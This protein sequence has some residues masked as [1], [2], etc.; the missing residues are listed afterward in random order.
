MTTG[1]AV[2]LLGV[3]HHGPGSAR[4]VVRALDALAPDVVAIE[5]PAEAEKV[6]G[7]VAGELLP[8]VALLGYVVDRPARAVFSPFAAFS[9]EW[10]ALRWAAAHGA[11]VRAI[12][13]PLAHSLVWEGDDGLR[14]VDPLGAL[15]AAAGY[16]DAERWWEDVVEQRDGAS[17]DDALAPLAAVAEAMAAVRADAPAPVG[18]EAAREACMRAVLR[19]AARDGATVAVVCGAWHVPALTPPWPAVS[20]DAALLRG[21]PKAKVAVT[22]VPW[23]NRRLAAATGYAAGVTAPGWYAHVFAHPGADGVTRWFADAARLLRAR[24]HP[25][26]PDHLIGATRL[27]TAVAALRERPAPGLADVLDAAHAVLTEGRPGPLALIHD[28]LVVGDALGSVPDDVPMVPLARDVAATQRRLRLK[29]EAGRRTLELDLRTDSGRDRSHLLHRLGALGVPWGV[30]EDGRGSSGTFRETW[31]L[32]WE[33]EL[34]I[35]LVEAAALG[36]TVVAAASAALRERAGSTDVLADLTALVEEA[37]LADLPDVVGPLVERLAA[38]A[39]GDADVAHLMDALG[40]LARARRY[41][42]VRATDTAA[43]AGVID[44]M[45]ARITVGVGPACGALDDD[46]AAAMAERLASV[47]AALALVDHPARRSSWPAE[48]ARLAAR[49]GG[50]GV[51]AGRATRL[52]YDGGDWDATAVERRLARAL[53]VGTPPRVGAAFVEGFLAGSG[54]VLVHDTTL[55]AVVDAWLATLAADVFVDVVPLLRRTFGAFAAA[56]RR[57]IGQLLAGRQSTDAATALGWDL[58]PARVEAAL[59]T[60]R[61]LLG[62]DEARWSG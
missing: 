32:H 58:D 10:V 2:H 34:A 15:A 23:T 61:V 42:D 38:R 8:P 46:A 56:E 12:D 49:D 55:L 39:A 35:R 36:T 48:M 6:L 33:P 45:V 52:V 18:E 47:Q 59:G 14:G 27:A 29:P 19:G 7:F 62:D 30:V 37:L 60:M 22:W 17:D 54:T 50:P 43:L 28:A 9:P 51:I 26:S 57:Q 5:L 4:A 13:L 11:P 1:P 31:R 20:A 24:D 16:D 25:V 41:G 21:L 44:A 40:P 53:S 3:R